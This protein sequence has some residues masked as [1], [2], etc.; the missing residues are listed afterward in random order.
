MA[1]GKASSLTCPVTVLK[2]NTTIALYCSKKL[3]YTAGDDG[4]CRGRS[5]RS[6]TG[7]AEVDPIFQVHDVFYILH[8]IWEPEFFYTNKAFIYLY[9]TINRTQFALKIDF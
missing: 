6:M 7:D 3:W 1:D 4:R 8:Y 2:T 5:Y 9:N